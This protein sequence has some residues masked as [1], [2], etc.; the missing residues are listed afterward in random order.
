MHAYM[1]SLLILIAVVVVV[2]GAWF[3]F[4]NKAEAPTVDVGGASNAMPVP[5]MEPAGGE[6]GVGGDTSMQ[7][8]ANVV[9]VE[10]VGK[11]FAFT[12]KE[13]R[14]KQ[15][16]TVQI[17]FTNEQGTHDLVLDE[18]GARTPV[19]QTGQKA[20]V[21]FVADKKGTFE[22][23]CSVGDHRARGMVGKLIVE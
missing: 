8:D 11:P 9:V 4:S 15:G 10:V 3:M 13:I 5:G 17:N 7:A 20:S 14:V 18:F 22:Y 2:G 19:I 16:Q 1:K 23:Y 6:M 12:P 21:T